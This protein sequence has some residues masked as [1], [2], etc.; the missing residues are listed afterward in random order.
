MSSQAKPD[1]IDYDAVV[2][3]SYEK[4]T[5]YGSANPCF[6]CGR[7]ITDKKSLMVH[8]TETGYLTTAAEGEV[9]NSQGFFP[10]G[11]GCARKLPKRF[12]FDHKLVS[13]P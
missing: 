13:L 3:A 12:I 10:I 1:F 7:E 11:S 8:Y 6:I 2:S 5:R 4:N 9:D